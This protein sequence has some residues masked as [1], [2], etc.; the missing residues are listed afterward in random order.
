MEIREIKCDVN[1]CKNRN[2]S[3]FSI[4]SHRA[5]DAAGGMEN[6]Y[7]T[8]DLCPSHTA[9]LAHKLLERVL[10]EDAKEFISKSDIDARLR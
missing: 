2:A 1:G 10:P 4:F 6:W 9:A 7:H 5:A 8:F 3:T